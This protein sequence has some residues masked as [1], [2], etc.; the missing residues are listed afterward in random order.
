MKGKKF[1]KKNGEEEERDE[2]TVEEEEAEEEEK[3]KKAEDLTEDDLEKS[4]GALEAEAADGDETS[5]RD[6]LL[7]KAQTGHLEGDERDELYQILG[8]EPRYEDSLA[9]TVTKGLEENDDLQ[10]ALDVSDYLREQ[11]GE[12]CKSLENLADEIEKGG[13]RQHQFNLVLAKAVAETGRMVKGMAE[14][15][16]VVESQPAHAPKAKRSNA[17][18]LQKSFAGQEGGEGNDLSKA[19]VLDALEQM[20][21]KSVQENRAGC[22]EDGFDLTVAASKME[23]FG[24]IDPRLLAK[25]RTH[26]AGGGA[27]VQ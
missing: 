7:A 10:K 21:E 17:Q 26:R 25:V 1:Q 23:Q 4:L 18:P 14:R 19:Q 15:I 27:T 6:T 20:I 9:E 24:T 13:N 3:S 8:G 11:H 2:E 12:L 5:R 22:T 16:G